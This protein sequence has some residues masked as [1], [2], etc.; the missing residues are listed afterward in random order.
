VLGSASIRQALPQKILHK[1]TLFYGWRILL[2][3]MRPSTHVRTASRQPTLHD[4][5]M[6][7]S[8]FAKN[9]GVIFHALSQDPFFLLR[10]SA[11]DLE[12]KI[13]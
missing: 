5:Q 3:A 6:A 7:P 11:L 1:L 13:K 8:L 9:F 12:Q 4:R 2:G 10:E